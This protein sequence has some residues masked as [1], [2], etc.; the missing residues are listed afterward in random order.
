MKLNLAWYLYYGR[1]LGMNR[2]E[3]LSTPVGEMS[4]M[5][6]CLQISNGANQKVYADVDDL[7]KVR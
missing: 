7:M 4:D 5:I 1:R 6:A 2:A 3:I